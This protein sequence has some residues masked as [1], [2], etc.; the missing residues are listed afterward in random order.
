MGG[1][2][3]ESSSYDPYY[4]ESQPIYGIPDDYELMT[5]KPATTEISDSD[6]EDSDP[7]Q[8]TMAPVYGSPSDLE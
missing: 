1:S 4:D 3:L 2:P 8:K 7:E 6:T 5:E